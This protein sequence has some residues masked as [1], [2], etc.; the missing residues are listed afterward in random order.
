M[1]CKWCNQ[2]NT[3]NN[4][5]CM[6][7]G[8]ELS[9][10]NNINSDQLNNNTLNDYN[11]NIYNNQI[12]NNYQTNV[13]NQIVEEKANIWLA[14]LS[15]FIPLAGLII[16][17]VKKDKQPKTAK[18]SGICALISFIL[19]LVLVIVGFFLIS[20]LSYSIFKSSVD[21][22]IN[23]AIEDIWSD[24]TNTNDNI[25]DVP[26]QDNL[27]MTTND[28]KKYQIIIN[29]KTITLPTTYNDIKTATN[30]SMKSSDEKPYLSAN[31]YT[32]INM[33]KNDKLAL[34]IEL[35]NK[36][37]SDLL[38][39]ECDVT[40]VTQ[41]KY[42]VSNGADAIIFPGNLTVGKEITE[43]EII[44]LFGTPYDTYEYSN[45]EYESK[46][47]KYVENT[48]W[49]TTNNYEIK[50]VNGIIDELQLDNRK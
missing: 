34:Y 20:T 13:S 22:E 38:Y 36:T 35:T 11:S 12:Q 47:Y 2:Q 8:K 45:S 23:D 48:M 5:F 17:I 26:E 50:I 4:K 6:H 30:A 15:W 19:N 18:V 25:Y 42:Q 41:T 32:L 31:Y 43:S 9:N 10:T 46:T 37:D 29:N 33:Y 21:E 16:F 7:C 14:I 3:E 40:S 44:E 1:I 27:E 49:T 24:D 39:T 28:W